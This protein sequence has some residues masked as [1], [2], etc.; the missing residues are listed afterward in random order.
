MKRKREDEVIVK[1]EQ[2]ASIPNRTGFRYQ[3]RENAIAHQISH[4]YRLL[5]AGRS[6]SGKTT[7]AVELILQ[8]LLRQVRRCYAVCPSFFIQQTLEPLRRVRGAFQRRDV[9]TNVSNEAFEKIFETQRQFKTPALLFLDDAAA[10]YCTNAGSKGPF[11]RLCIQSSHLNLS[12]VAIFQGITQACKPL[13]YNCEGVIVFMPNGERETKTI[14]E[15]FN[16]DSSNPGMR[17]MMLQALNVA[18]MEHRFAFIHKS[19]PQARFYAGFTK[20][21]TF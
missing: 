9:F 3:L 4:P 20:Q 16:I 6:T 12:V 18:W 5:I 1:Q 7:L 17:K 8:Q 11:A 14:I 10:E 2:H 21:I 13:R 19:F 15:E